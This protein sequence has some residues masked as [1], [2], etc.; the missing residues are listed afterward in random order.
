MA[1]SWEFNEQTPKPN[2][3]FVSRA[4][5]L[6]SV[7]T[8]I[9]YEQ[10]KLAE[11]LRNVTCAAQVHGVRLLYN[12]L[13]E[14]IKRSSVTKSSPE[15]CRRLYKEPLIS[16]HE[17]SR[18]T[19]L[20]LCPSVYTIKKKWSGFSFIDFQLWTGKWRHT[21]FGDSCHRKLK[22]NTG[23]RNRPS[24]WHYTLLCHFHISPL[25]KMDRVWRKDTE[26]NTCCPGDGQRLECLCTTLFSNSNGSLY[27]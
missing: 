7:I 14:E 17:H 27:F 23:G 8:G 4:E 21:L 26:I 9:K 2:G 11:K 12:A 22:V 16:Y 13:W 25:N 5:S 6:G 24:W 1:Y 18:Y 15:T 3:Y 10:P 20:L 19:T